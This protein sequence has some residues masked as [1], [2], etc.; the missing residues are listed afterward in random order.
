[1]RDGLHHL[2]DPEQLPADL[3]EVNHLRRAGS[4]SDRRSFL[5]SL[6]LPAGRSSPARYHAGMKRIPAVLAPVLLLTALALPAGQ[7][8]APR[9]GWRRRT[10]PNTPTGCRASSS[11]L[12]A[13]ATGSSCVT[14]TWWKGSSTRWTPS[15]SR[16][17]WTRSWSR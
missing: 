14:A 15:A 4:V 17:T 1:H 2:A 9:G 5:R 7:A 3:A 16:W 11:P 13:P 10:T 6:T 8:P 12:P